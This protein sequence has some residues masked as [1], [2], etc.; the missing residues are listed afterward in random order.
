MS[1]VRWRVGGERGAAHG[2]PFLTTS[3]R[4]GH[5]PFVMRPARQ[6]TWRTLA[7]PST[8]D[9]TDR[10]ES[11]RAY[12]ARRIHDAIVAPQGGDCCVVD[13]L[14]FR[15]RWRLG[16]PTQSERKQSRVPP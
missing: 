6:K 4:T 10:Q 12:M 9:E 13:L 7:F 11:M 5:A 3:R 8:P 15:S 1:Y 16:E 14:R 2:G